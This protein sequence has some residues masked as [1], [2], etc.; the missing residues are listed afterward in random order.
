MATANVISMIAQPVHMSYLCFETG[1]ILDTCAAQL[2]AAVDDIPFQKLTGQVKASGTIPGDP[3]R[4]R[5]D[6]DGVMQ[7]AKKFA[8]ATLRNEDRKTFLDSAVNSRQNIYFS[9][10]AN[11][12]S[13]ISTI[14][15][16]YHKTS[17]ASNP[18]LLELLSDLAN[19][20]LT[21][22]GEAYSEDDRTGVVKAATSCLETTTTSSGSS[23]RAGKFYQE[24]VGRIIPNG[25]KLPHDLPLPWEGTLQ[26]SKL[27]WPSGYESKRFISD[28]ATPGTALTVGVNFEESTNAGRSAGSQSAKHVDYEY[29]MPYLE[30]QARNLRAQISL[31]DQK[32]GLFMFGQTIPHLAQIFKNELAAVDHDVYQL[33]I[34]LLRTVLISPHPG[35]VTGIYKN[36]GDAVSA[37]EPVLRV[38]DNRVVHLIANLVLYG[39]I[40]IGNT[41]TV[42]TTLG[43]AAHPSTTLSGSV[44]AARGQGSGGRWEV[45]VK[46]NNIDGAGNVILPLG[47]TFDAEYTTV[48]IV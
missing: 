12:A 47:Y 13:V 42:T 2:G 37:G 19:Q 39:P 15:G 45:V 41:A 11:A 1:G 31:N 9:K 27:L 25:T 4:L 5:G 29:R 35:V 26:G 40:A 10:H 46:I 21:E 16:T 38:E 8:L 43:G 36:P 28:G 3:S 20:Q 14:E 18:N 24:S 17:P 7:M 48:T 34:A 30:A 32:F 23:N 22:L 33:Q 6:A 44:V